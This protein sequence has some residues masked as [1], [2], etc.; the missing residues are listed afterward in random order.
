MKKLLLLLCLFAAPCFAQSNGGAITATAAT[1]PTSN[2]TS[3]VV[4][5][6]PIKSTYGVIAITG[7]F[8]ATLQFEASGDGG[9]SWVAISATP[10]NSATAVTSTTAVGTWQVNIQGY[11]GLRVRCSAFTSGTAQVSINIGTH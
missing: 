4:A 6:V 8:S 1:C 10:S 7:T 3:C 11:Y 2:T 5:N 9:A